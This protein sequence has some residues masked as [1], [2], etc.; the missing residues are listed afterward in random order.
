MSNE[1]QPK[2]ALNVYTVMLIGSTLLMLVACIMMYLA[3]V[4]EAA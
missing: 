3:W 1:N 4:K 2:Q